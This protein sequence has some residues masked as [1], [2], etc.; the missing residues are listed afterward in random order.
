MH[1]KIIKKNH[2]KIVH[3]SLKF[4]KKNNFFRKYNFI[5][6]IFLKIYFSFILMLQFITKLMNI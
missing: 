2:K 5:S 1:I 3:L 4:K 6:K